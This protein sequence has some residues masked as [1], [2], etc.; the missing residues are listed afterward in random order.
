MIHR[1]QKVSLATHLTRR[2]GTYYFRARIPLELVEAF[3]RAE[4]SRSL[5]TKDPNEAK[6][7][8]PAAQSEF[9]AECDAKRR[10]VTA[11]AAPS[12]S[13]DASVSRDDLIR[14]A[15]EYYAWE[16]ERD[17]EDRRRFGEGPSTREFLIKLAAPKL[18]EMVA[19][20]ALAVGGEAGKV[21]VTH[22]AEVI[23]QREGL[24]MQ[25]PVHE[26]VVQ[27][28]LRAHVE[29][30]ARQRERDDGNFGGRPGDDLLL[31]PLKAIPVVAPK[32]AGGDD[33]LAILCTRYAAERRDVSSEW[34]SAISTALNEFQN[35]FG[36]ERSLVEVTRKNVAAYKDALMSISAHA[37]REAGKSTFK[38]LMK[39][40][41]KI[42][43][44]GLANGSINR[45]LSAL[46]TFGAWAVKH[47]HVDQNVFGGLAMKKNRVTRRPFNAEQLQTVFTSPL[48]VGC[49]S[50]KRGDEGRSGQHLV[51][52]WR[53]WCMPLALFT[54]ARLGE[55]IQLRVEDVRRVDGVDGI[56]INEWAEQGGEES[57][58]RVK[59]AGSARFV[60]LHPTLVSIGF[61]DH[62][63]RQR[64]AAQVR[65]FPGFKADS[66]GREATRPSKILNRYL[67]RIGVKKGVAL[68]FH[69]FRH[70]FID[71]LRRAEHTD[72]TIASIV[73][74]SR[75]EGLAV[76][77]GYGEEAP[78]AIFG[79]KRKATI[80]ASVDFGDLNLSHLTPAARLASRPKPS[81]PALSASA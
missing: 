25:G 27:A 54:G 81:N 65:V 39:R 74:H 50:P 45:R 75:G 77:G 58:K 7:L 18:N 13:A 34:Q 29:A 61:L 2:E 32:T 9:Y 48:F 46:T 47:G 67:A 4:V 44:K 51:D 17:E 70:T 36:A 35:F 26:E 80:I 12:P 43:E 33:S 1:S 42:G 24:P 73:G 21:F 6:R 10:H 20:K 60:P 57:G 78:V 19:R 14:F 11:S 5:R 30:S 69:S 64:A 23:C 72:Q 15:Q 8:L 31:T 40:G 37:S 49:A 63:E 68:V 38:E 52:D 76:T 41:R 79:A 55:L 28:L 71:G 66:L 56:Q 16:L 53:Y 3:G 62:V 22:Y 59:S